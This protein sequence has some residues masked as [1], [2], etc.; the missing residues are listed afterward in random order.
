MEKEVTVELGEHIAG[1]LQS[2]GDGVVDNWDKAQCN[3]FF[4]RL[5][6]SSTRK[7]SRLHILVHKV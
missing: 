4:F 7:R 1:C 2:K 6:F 3:H 5:C